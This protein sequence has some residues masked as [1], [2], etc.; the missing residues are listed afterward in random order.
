[1]ATLL[2]V[3]NVADYFR[4]LIDEPSKTFVDDAIIQ[5]WLAIGADNYYQFITDQNPERFAAQHTATLANAREYDLTGILLGAAAPNR[6]LQLLR[7]VRVD[8][9]G[10]INQHFQGCNNIDQLDTQEFGIVRYT[11]QNTKLLFSAD[12]T[13]S[14]R[15]DYIPV[16]TVDWTKTASGDSEFIDD[17][18]PFHDLI[19]LYA[20]MQY[21]AADNQPN[22]MIERLLVAR[23][24]AFANH[25]A[26]G[27]LVNANRFVQME[28]PWY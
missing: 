27:E 18:I 6:M 2:F 1:M 23:Q 4:N 19:A 9:S 28:D 22:P 12:I 11:M 7:V 26:R 25:I 24:K 17:L 16:S 15:L 10:K 5:S 20:A 13:G 3:E 14:I 8:A 21:F